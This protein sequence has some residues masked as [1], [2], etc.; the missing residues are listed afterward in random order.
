MF[1]VVL[2][3]VLNAL[4]QSRKNFEETASDDWKAKAH[5]TKFAI[6]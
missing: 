6:L 2:L 4:K 5:R 3:R 1:S